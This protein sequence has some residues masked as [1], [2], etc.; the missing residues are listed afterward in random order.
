MSPAVTQ[1]GPS[2]GAEGLSYQWMLDIGTTAEGGTVTYTNLPDVTGIDPGRSDVTADGT[3]YA[4]QGQTSETKQAT[5]FAPKFDVK[6]VIGKD[7]AVQPA[8]ETLIAAADSIGSGS[9]VPIRIYSTKIKKLAYAG[10]ASVGW[11]RKNTDN[12]AIEF[13]SFECKG[14]GDFKPI[15]NPAFAAA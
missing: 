12:A 4:N 2:T 15:A 10:T 14:Q 7:G 8:L 13:M 3:T 5:N 1:Q 9:V 6:P 11:S